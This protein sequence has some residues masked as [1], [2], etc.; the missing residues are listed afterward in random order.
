MEKI[1]TAEE[2]LEKES[3]QFVKI[4]SRIIGSPDYEVKIMLIEFAKLHVKAALDSIYEEAKHG[5]EE[6][7]KWLK[8][9]FDSYPLENIK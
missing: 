8:E 6:H 5:D 4:H 3:T 1:P 9:K 2:F 7:Q